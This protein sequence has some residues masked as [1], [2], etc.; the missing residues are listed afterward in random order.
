[1][2]IAAALA[3]RAA[4]PG[5]DTQRAHPDELGV[6]EQSVERVQLLRANLVCPDDHVSELRQ[7]QAQELRIWCSAA[8]PE[9]Y[10]AFSANIDQAERADVCVQAAS[11]L[12]RIDASSH[13]DC[14]QHPG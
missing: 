8:T 13:L 4:A 12:L 2:D 6:I 7:R 3:N 14:T 5:G 11:V 1:M 9:A 10:L